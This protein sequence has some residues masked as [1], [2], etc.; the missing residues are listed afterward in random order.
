MGQ[1][2]ELHDLLV[3]LL[4]SQYVYFQPKTNTKMQYPAIVYYLD[5]IDTKF[6]DNN[7]YSKTLRYQVTAIDHDPDSDIRDKIAAL[8]MNQFDR[9]FT[10]D[11]LYHHVFSLYF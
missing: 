11:N 1:R 8:P 5:D 10:A 7:P 4:G 2:L 6:A 9:C 3:G